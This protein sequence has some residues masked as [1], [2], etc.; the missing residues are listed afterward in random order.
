VVGVE[1]LE[2]LAAVVLVG[3]LRAVEGDV[4][5]L[6]GAAQREQRRHGRAQRHEGEQRHQGR[7][8]LEAG[9]RHSLHDCG[10]AGCV[11]HDC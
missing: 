5:V 6:G 10:G 3:V 8:L 2:L 1:E 4:R 7:V 11:D 9:E